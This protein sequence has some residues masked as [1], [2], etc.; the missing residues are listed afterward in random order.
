METGYIHLYTGN[1]KGKTS[2]AFGQV[3]R[4]SGY[5][6]KSLVIQFMKGQ[7]T[8]E[9]S[10]AERTGGLISVEQYGSTEFFIPG[11]SNLIEHRGF[12]KKGYNRAREA[13]VSGEYDIIVCDEIIGAFNNGLVSYEEILSLIEIKTETVELILTGRDAP[14]DLFERCDIV[15]EMKEIKH[16]YCIRQIN[17]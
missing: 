9:T 5:G 16:Y 13:L 8:G 3:F 14:S 4:A 15:T 1:G 6:L 2:A 17:G 12:F 10:A 11:T 7:K